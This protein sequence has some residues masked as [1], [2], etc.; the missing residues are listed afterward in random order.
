[1][2]ANRPLATLSSANNHSA[3]DGDLKFSAL[4]V[5][6]RLL[7]RV[8]HE[9]FD[10][11]PRRFELQPELFLK[12]GKDRGIVGQVRRCA[13]RREHQRESEHAREAEALAEA[14]GDERNAD[15]ADPATRDQHRWFGTH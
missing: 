6:C 15:S 9:Q 10:R 12:G 1:M 11:A 5:R 14:L 4:S 13:K 2:V 7:N 3:T 8:D